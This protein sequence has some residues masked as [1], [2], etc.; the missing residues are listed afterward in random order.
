MERD[1]LKDQ[2]IDEIKMD[3]REI[4][5]GGEGCGGFAWFRIGTVGRL[6]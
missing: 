4:G 2:G 5:W 1:H 3:L 6:W